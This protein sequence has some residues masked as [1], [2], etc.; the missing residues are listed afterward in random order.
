M[1]KRNDLE[2]QMK[3]KKE[4]TKKKWSK[5]KYIVLALAVMIGAATTEGIISYLT[6]K[7]TVTNVF[8]TGNVQ[9]QIHEDQW[10]ALAD[11]NKNN[12]PDIAEKM[13]PLES[14]TKDPSVK[15]IGSNSA[16]V[17][18]EV[19]IP[20]KSVITADVNGNKLNNGV[21]KATELFGFA[22]KSGWTMMGTKQVTSDTATYVYGYN[23]KLAPNVQTTTLFD[24]IQ[25]ANVIENQIDNTTQ[26]IVINAYAVQS[27][28]V[29]DLKTAW[30]IISN[31]KQ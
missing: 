16:W 29:A 28:G 4:N 9:I 20:V 11:A 19:K 27:D 14:V 5:K 15:N 13:L 22:P 3:T 1:D 31:Q 30:N 8:T 24:S 25:L 17:F 23:T 18:L 21:A 2:N 12:I 26:N 10:D 7:E 6:D